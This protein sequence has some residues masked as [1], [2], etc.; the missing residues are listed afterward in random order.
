MHVIETYFEC[1]GF[2][3]RFIQGGTSVYLWN[4]ARAVARAGHRVS[5]VTPA[6]GRLADLRELTDVRDLPYRDSYELPLVLDPRVWRD[7][8]PDEVRVPLST[9]A[10]HLALDGVDLYFLSNE[11]LDSLPD[12]FYPSYHTKG[13]DLVFFKPIAYQVDSVRFIRQ[14][15]AG[16]RAVVHAHEPYYHYLM[17]AAFR[18]DPDKQ[19]VSTVQSNMPI[20]KSEYQPLVSRLLDFLDT[21]L[22][23]PP[24]DPAPDRSLAPMIQ[25]QQRTHLHYAYPDDHV[26]IYDLV[27]EHADRIDF[28]SPGHRRF[29]SD[30]ANTP[31]EQVFATLPAA[32]TVQ[33][34]AAKQ[35]VGGCAIGEAWTGA[36]PD[37]DRTSVLAGLGLDPAL[38]TFFHNARYAVH[39]KGQVELIRAVDRALTEGL[40]ANIIVRCISDAGIDDPLF[41]EVAARHPGRIHLEWHRVD[42]KRIVEYA[43][44]ADFCLFPSKFEMDT[45]L[46]AMGEAMACGAVPI[47]TAQEGMA[48]FGHVPDPLTGPLPPGATGF[49]VN[50]SFAEDDP[51][52][53]DALVDRMHAAVRLLREDPER[54]AAMS[55]NAAATARAFT[56]DRCAE[57]QLATFTALQGGVLPELPVERIL[58]HGWFDLLPETAWTDHREAV[59]EAALRRGNIEAY[60]RCRPVDDEAARQLFEAA[61][62]RA[63][64]AACAR[65]AEGRPHL[66]TRLRER[67]ELSV[68]RL[69]HQMPH[70]VRAE[71]V[72]PGDPDDLRAPTTVLPMARSDDG[73]EVALPAGTTSPL[74]VL[75]TLASGRAT[76]DVVG[77]A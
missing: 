68:G 6:H 40:A 64:T 17:P 51:L 21:R 44:S 18:A 67:Y 54:Y 50:R 30:F 53:V 45:F 23:L 4:L 22:E 49:A 56:W 57:R 9:T 74:H 10:H 61:W 38:P 47:A 5:I 1:G 34:H 37:V 11:L 75:L 29:Y 76:W 7:G 71:L 36:R 39:H 70:V 25:Y 73:F 35:V 62:A 77:H 2:D 63:D 15:F 32:E 46:I 26:R 24:P 65:T 28:L 52:L 14:F 58:E 16:E 55:A 19:V 33:R 27:A 66:S 8:F 59:A 69:R 48:H 43:S 3:H 31:F 72:L 12:S 41:H 13:R 42:D 60:G 20:G